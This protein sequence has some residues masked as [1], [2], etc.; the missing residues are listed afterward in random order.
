MLAPVG[1]IPHAWP[2]IMPHGWQSTPTRAS[3]QIQTTNNSNS[4][5]NNNDDDNDRHHTAAP[6]YGTQAIIVPTPNPNYYIPTRGWQSLKRWLRALTSPVR[7]CCFDLVLHSKPGAPKKKGVVIFSRLSKSTHRSST[8][9]PLMSKSSSC[10]GKHPSLIPSSLIFPSIF[11][12]ERPLC[13]VL[14]V[15]QY[16]ALCWNYR[17]A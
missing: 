3:K 7:C 9:C 15:R 1:G 13:P 16:V 8:I 5:N 2:C 10:G 4:S 12:R 14:E 17:L 11:C 6:Q